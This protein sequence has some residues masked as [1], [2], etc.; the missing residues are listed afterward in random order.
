MKIAIKP[1]Y[2]VAALMSSQSD[3]LV[4]GE[5]EIMEIVD[6]VM[7]NLRL[8]DE[9]SNIDINLRNQLLQKHVTAAEEYYSHFSSEDFA[10]MMLVDMLIKKGGEADDE[11]EK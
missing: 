9:I 10:S 6:S 8:Y 2:P 11:E 4:E 1:P 5:R 3:S 7:R